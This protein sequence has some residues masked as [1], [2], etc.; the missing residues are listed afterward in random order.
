MYFAAV[1]GKVIDGQN[2]P[3]SAVSLTDCGNSKFSSDMQLKI[4]GHTGNKWVNTNWV[5]LNDSGKKSAGFIS[6]F[7][8]VPNII[9]FSFTPP[10]SYRCSTWTSTYPAGNYHDFRGTG[11][12]DGTCHGIIPVVPYSNPTQSMNQSQGTQ[13]LFGIEPISDKKAK[14]T[15]ATGTL[16]CYSDTGDAN[17]D[18]KVDGK[19]YVITLKNFGKRSNKDSHSG[20]FNKDGLVDKKDLDIILKY[21]KF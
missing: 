1:M 14:P 16:T 19:D 7:M 21:L 20:D 13:L 9:V 18:G 4:M 8:K 2:T 10:A 3:W 5:C 11:R 17:C 12:P 6:E 15:A